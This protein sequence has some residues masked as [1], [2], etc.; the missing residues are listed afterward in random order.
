M[1]WAE[2]DGADYIFGL[3]GNPAL[4]ALMAE[5]ADNLRFHHARSNQPKTP[6]GRSMRHGAA[7]MRRH[8]LA[9]QEDL[10]GPG[11]DPRLDLVADET[12]RNA[13]V[14][15]GD[16]DVVVKIDATALPLRRTGDCSSR[17]RPLRVSSSSGNDIPPARAISRLIW[18]VTR[19]FCLAMDFELVFGRGVVAAVAGVGV[20]PLDGIADERLDRGDD[21]D[22]GVSVV[23]IAGQRLPGDELAVLATLQ[24]GGDAHLDAELVGL[25][26]FALAYRSIQKQARLCSCY[27]GDN[28][29]DDCNNSHCSY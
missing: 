2:N 8:A 10:D 18:G 28:R 11:G 16:L 27:A 19:R 7:Q 26:R 17:R 12:V 20:E 15:L 4:D 14:V 24:G 13:V 29:N 3:A 9:A 22:E 6:G 21:A 1:E 23:G 5:T 25:V